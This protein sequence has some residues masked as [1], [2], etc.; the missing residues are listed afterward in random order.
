MC[1]TSPTES[2]NSIFT[3]LELLKHCQRYILIILCSLF[4]F[5]NVGF[6]MSFL[7]FFLPSHGFYGGWILSRQL[8]SLAFWDGVEEEM[9]FKFG[10][11]PAQKLGVGGIERST[12]EWKYFCHRHIII[13]IPVL[14]L[15]CDNCFGTFLDSL[16]SY[17]NNCSSPSSYS[18]HNC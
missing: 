18:C 11:H 8:V 17:W 14:Q 15:D 1:Y 13:L 4:I 3:N 12:L 9:H 7:S 10:H 5:A 2:C 16:L 6:P